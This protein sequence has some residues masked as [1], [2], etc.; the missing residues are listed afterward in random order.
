MI[1]FAP[2]QP[3]A[4]PKPF[5]AQFVILPLIFETYHNR[6]VDVGELFFVGSTANQYCYLITN[7]GVL[8]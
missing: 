8:F 3:T 7:V 1:Y 5:S 6:C 2:N 4:K